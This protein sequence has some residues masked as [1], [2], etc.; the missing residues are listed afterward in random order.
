MTELDLAFIAGTSVGAG[1]V[2]LCVAL[3]WI[4][5]SL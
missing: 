5:D 3:D 2:L 4:M 1:L